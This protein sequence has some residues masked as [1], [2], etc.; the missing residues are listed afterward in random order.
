M[1]KHIAVIEERQFITKEFADTLA[2]KLPAPYLRLHDPVQKTII[3]F[4]ASESA[5]QAVDRENYQRAIEEVEQA[6][7]FSPNDPTVWQAFGKL[8]DKI[9]QSDRAQTALGVLNSFATSRR[10]C[11]NRLL[12]QLLKLGSA[13][14]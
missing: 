9:G 14:P 8:Y 7:L 6:R 5:Q 10:R 11:Q 12:Q 2:G 1:K 13:T 4:A 3:E